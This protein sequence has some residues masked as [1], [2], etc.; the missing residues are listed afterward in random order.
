VSEHHSQPTASRRHGDGLAFRTSYD[1]D[2]ITVI[3]AERSRQHTA[4]VTPSTGG[5]DASRFDAGLSGGRAV[6]AFVVQDGHVRWRPAVDITR[7]LVTAEVVVGAVLVAQR[8]AARPSAARASVTMGPGGWVSMKGG[9]M[10]VRPARR[11]W[12]PLPA[13]TTG[14][15]P[16]PL[17]KR[18]VWARMLAATALQSL[19]RA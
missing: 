16:G 10:S 13:P 14:A 8:L 5:H 15:L 1:R 11:G 17:S 9:L 6:G 12:L 3:T 18:P 7:L 2:D 19:L 4:A